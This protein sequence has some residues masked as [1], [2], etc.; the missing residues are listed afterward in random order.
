MQISGNLNS[1]FNSHR[2]FD[3]SIHNHRLPIWELPD[4]LSLM[5]SL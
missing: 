3:L 1:D 4:E 5:K 2:S